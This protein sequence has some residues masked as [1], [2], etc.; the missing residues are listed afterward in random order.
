MK[1]LL[2]RILICLILGTIINIAVAWGC[3]ALLSTPPVVANSGWS[4]RHGAGYYEM[5]ASSD[6]FQSDW[7]LVDVTGTSFISRTKQI[8]AA[9]ELENDVPGSV[10]QLLGFGNGNF[11]PDYYRMSSVRGFGWPFQSFAR[12]TF[13]RGTRAIHGGWASTGQS[14]QYTMEVSS[15][16]SLP[17]YPMWSAFCANALIYAISLFLMIAS[18][19]AV[20]RWLRSRPGHCPKCNYDLRG[21]LSVGC[22]ECGWRRETSTPTNSS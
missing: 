18:Y 2:T 20:K 7:G 13:E 3:A 21:D 16:T 12:S 14:T 6:A 9:S 11:P 17:L 15:K 22:P 5:F 1:R 19:Q 8:A 10:L 4:W